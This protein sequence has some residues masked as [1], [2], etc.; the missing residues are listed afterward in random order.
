MAADRR[1]R[2]SP[3]PVCILCGS[4]GELAYSGL[5]DRLFSASGTWDFKKCSNIECGLIWPDPMPLTEDIGKAYLNYYTHTARNEAA[6]PGILKRIYRGM[7]RGYWAQKYNYH[8][9]SATLAQKI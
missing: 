6:K 8:P 1:I 5:R 9:G 4:K 3:C 2:T 7:K